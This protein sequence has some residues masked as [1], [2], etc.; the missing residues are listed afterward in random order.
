MGEARPGQ[1]EA[2]LVDYGI[3]VTKKA[4]NPQVLLRLAW[5]DQDGDQH[6]RTYYAQLTDGTPRNIT[7]GVLKSLGFDVERHTLE[8]LV[9]GPASGVL[10]MERKVQI[11]VKTT[12]GQDGKTYLNIDRVGSAPAL[13]GNKDESKAALARLGLSGSLKGKIDVPVTA[14]VAEPLP[15]DDVPF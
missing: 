3:G 13:Q 10:D 14:P 5:D 6:I 4:G 11:S 12:I 9:D 7:M 15:T 8:A 1:Y 2:R